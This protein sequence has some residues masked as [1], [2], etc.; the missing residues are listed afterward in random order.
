M[1][2]FHAGDERQAGVVGAKGLFSDVA[3]HVRV[4]AETLDGAAVVA[5]LC[6]K[7]GLVCRIR[8]H[9]V[10]GLGKRMAHQRG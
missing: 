6:Q 9:T 3:D 7:S 8:H 10:T 5:H 2:T 4:G 1:V